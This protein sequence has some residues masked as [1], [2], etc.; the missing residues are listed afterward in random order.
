MNRR[1]I[2]KNL[3]PK[4]RSVDEVVHYYADL[5]CK[6]WTLITRTFPLGIQ[7]PALFPIKTFIV[8]ILYIL[9]NGLCVSRVQVIP[10]DS[11]LASVLPEANTLDSYSVNKPT[12]TACKNNILKAYREASEI[13]HMPPQKLMLP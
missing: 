9:K 3:I 7:T 12:F 5:A 8:S 11:Y 1:Y 13:Y 2:F 6:Y 10:K 4:D